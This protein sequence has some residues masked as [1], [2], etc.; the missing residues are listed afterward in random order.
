MSTLDIRPP[1]VRF[2]IGRDRRVVKDSAGPTT[3]RGDTGGLASW[4]DL[5]FDHGNKPACLLGD[6]KLSF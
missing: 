1:L 5:D 3:G 6:W 2:H 4:L